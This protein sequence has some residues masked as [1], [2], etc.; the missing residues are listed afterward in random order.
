MGKEELFCLHI[1]WNK[2]SGINRAF[3]ENPH[4]AF[5]AQFSGYC[6]EFCLFAMKDGIG[7]LLMFMLL[8]F[9]HGTKWNKSCFVPMDD[10]GFA[11]SSCCAGVNGAGAPK[12]LLLQ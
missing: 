11:E 9:S 5:P 6:A 10:A 2:M 4:G 3:L 7:E 12:L 8:H 1:N